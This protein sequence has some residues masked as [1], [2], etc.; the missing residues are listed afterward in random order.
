MI[1]SAQKNSE[2][3]QRFGRLF[4]L[5]HDDKRLNAESW[6][7]CQPCKK[8]QL[9]GKEII[10]TQPSSSFWVYLLGVLTSLLGGYFLI[11]HADQVSRNLWGISLL[12]WGI[13]ALIAG[14][15]YQA[16][17]YQLKCAGRPYVAWTS[18]WEVIYL[19]FQ[20]L[21][22]NVMLVAV[23]YSCLPE[24]GQL[25]AIAIAV[26]VSIGYTLMVFWG[27]FKPV[28]AL[29]TFELMVHI[30]TPCI[31]FLSALNAWRYWQ[32]SQS[33]DLALLGTW[34]SLVFSMWL[35][36]LYFKAG[37]S[38]KLWVKGK[39]FSENDVLHLALI[40]W[41]VYITLLVAPLVK[42]I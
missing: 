35:Y 23:A 8:Y 18:W 20:Q 22:I 38:E 14:T 11:T 3:D 9:F 12:L 33:L 16:F 15:S 13:G 42:D 4:T 24:V 34:L 26:I 27:A 25:F 29:L 31:I 41:V 36:W 39:W 6:F 37:I 1:K 17:A 2:V 40:A 5:V 10:I 7:T 21:S 30:C 28:K 19:I 32:F